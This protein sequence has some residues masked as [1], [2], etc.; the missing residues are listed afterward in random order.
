MC[1]IYAFALQLK[2]WNYVRIAKGIHVALIE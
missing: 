2:S 1:T